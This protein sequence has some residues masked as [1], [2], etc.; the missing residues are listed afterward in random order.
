MSR[1]AEILAAVKQVDRL[2]TAIQKALK[3]LRDPR[4][5]MQ[6]LAKVLQLDP[7][8]T[9]NLLKV[10]NSPYFGSVR[11]ITSVRDA[12]VRLG[13]QRVFQLVLT[14]GVAPRLSTEV[15]GYGLDPGQLLEH[16][17]TVALAAEQL[18]RELHITPPDYT[19]TAG[20]LS[21]VG[22]TVLGTFVGVDAG[23]ILELAR[24]QGL[25]FEAAEQRVLGIDHAEVGAALL[26][27]WEL[28]EPIVNVVRHRLHPENAPSRDVALDLVHVADVLAKCTGVGLG[29]DGMNYR[30]SEAVAERLGLTP[31]VLDRCTAQIMA[32]VAELKTV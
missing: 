17:I 6:A 25:T 32:H 31:E 10:A 12:L 8:I 11:E 16:S 13:S 19:F 5:D 3:V 26:Q 22:K 14:S 9:A 1:R 15:K 30:P 4:S 20:L 24:Q 23:P 21:D 28:P 27:F 7:G 18:A 2:P 29:I